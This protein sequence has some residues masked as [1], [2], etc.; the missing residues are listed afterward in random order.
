MKKPSDVKSEA[1]VQPLRKGNRQSQSEWTFLKISA[2]IVLCFLVLVAVLTIIYPLMPW[3]SPLGDFFLFKP[4]RSDGQAVNALDAE[5][6][7]TAAST[8][9]LWLTEPPMEGKTAVVINTPL[10]DAA[11]TITPAPTLNLRQTA[12]PT[13]TPAPT[14]AEPILQPTSPF[15]TY[16]PQPGSPIYLH[17]KPSEGDE[18]CGALTLAGQVFNDQSL[19]Q[20]GLTIVVEGEIASKPYLRKAETGSALQYGPGGYEIM[21]ASQP[22]ESKN[23]LFAQVLDP[24]GMPLS[25]KVPFDTYRACE[26]NLIVIN[27][28]QK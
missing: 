17:L 18:G 6:R 24:Q 11:A 8:I 9:D 19:P 21:L 10:R 22:F 25:P 2:F 13:I 12:A 4:A 3:E 15:H 7:I 26:K 20:V 23:A 16:R 28:V 14:I 27:F 5:L 1:K